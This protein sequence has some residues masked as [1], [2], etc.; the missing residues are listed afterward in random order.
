[1]LAISI[2]LNCAIVAMSVGVFLPTEKPQLTL[3]YRKI[4]KREPVPSTH[5]SSSVFRAIV[6]DQEIHARNLGNYR[7]NGYF[8][9]FFFVICGNNQQ[10]FQSNSLPVPYFAITYLIANLSRQIDSILTRK[11]PRFVE[12]ILH[13]HSKLPPEL[14]WS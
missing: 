14:W 2:K 1:M 8:Q 7:S 10:C 11:E 6:Y 5:L 4:Q 13:L 9:R 12:S 3:S